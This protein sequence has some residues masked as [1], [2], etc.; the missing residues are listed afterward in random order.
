MQK[1]KSTFFF[2]CFF[3]PAV[4]W[5]DLFPHKVLPPDSTSPAECWLVR[6]NQRPGGWRR[7]QSA[8]LKTQSGHRLCALATKSADPPVCNH[9]KSLF[10]GIQIKPQRRNPGNRRRDSVSSLAKACRY[11]GGPRLPVLSTFLLHSDDFCAKIQTHRL[12]DSFT[13]TS[14]FTCDVSKALRLTVAAKPKLP[15]Q[16]VNSLQRC[17]INAMIRRLSSIDP[18]RLAGLFL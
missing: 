2:C 4:I 18:Q 13:N 11:S 14:D 10:V 5:M 17:K 7:Q 6:N 1:C 9:L 3:P 16:A 15:R 12:A 8:V